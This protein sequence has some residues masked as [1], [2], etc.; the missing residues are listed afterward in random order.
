MNNRIIII[1]TFL[2]GLISGLGEIRADCPFHTRLPDDFIV[3]PGRPGASHSH[4][5]YG[6]TAIDADTTLTKMQNSATSCDPKFDHSAYWTPTLISNGNNIAADRVTIYYHT[7][8]NFDKVE[9]IPTGLR[10]ITRKYKWSCQGTT[11]TVKTPTDPILFCGNEKVEVLLN[12]PDCWDGINL[13]SANHM[14]HMA[15]SSN[16]L[17]PSTHPRFLPRLQLKITYPING[18]GNVTLSSG[19]GT[20]AHA[21]FVNSFDPNA[22]QLRINECL[23]KNK[24]CPSNLPGD[25]FIIPTYESNPVEQPVRNF[26]FRVQPIEPT[27]TT[28]KHP[29]E[30]P[31]T[32]FDFDSAANN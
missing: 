24:K 9:I 29:F 3:F 15:Y 32:E 19:S 23:K 28:D 17:C 5:F 10:I 22:F 16:N 21:D 13:D 27:F 7:F 18:Q 12:F 11:G 2:F 30:Q 4:D 26:A 20:T 25:A 6:A 14:S 31:F 8:A 1:L